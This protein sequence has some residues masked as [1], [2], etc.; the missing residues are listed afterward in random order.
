M[1]LVIDSS[2]FISHMGTNDEFT[3]TSQ[4]FFKILFENKEKVVIP[5][6]VI[7]ETLT[8]L[9]QQQHPNLQIIFKN[10]QDFDAIPLDM[11]LL[12]KLRGILLKSTVTLKASDLV[13]AL[14]AK[15]ADAVLISWDK[16]MLTE[17]SICPVLTPKQY[18]V[19]VKSN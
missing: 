17:T 5:T 15:V 12:E 8:V 19:K 1:K 10:F 13:I 9:K 7:A 3:P 4:L 18:I 16:R 6:L 2:V 11:G 14:T